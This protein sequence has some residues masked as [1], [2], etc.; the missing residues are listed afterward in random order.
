[1]EWRDWIMLASCQFKG[2]GGMGSIPTNLSFDSLLGNTYLSSDRFLAMVEI[3][4]PIELTISEIRRVRPKVVENLGP[5][6]DRR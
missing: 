4:A 6:A 1:M 3:H 2:V 5:S